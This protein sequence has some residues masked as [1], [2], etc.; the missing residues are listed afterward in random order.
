MALVGCS[1]SED[2]QQDGGD[3]E[4]D[5]VELELDCSNKFLSKRSIQ[6]IGK[7]H[8]SLVFRLRQPN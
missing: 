8:C 4:V 7:T 1:C 2:T 3:V 5:L 6:S